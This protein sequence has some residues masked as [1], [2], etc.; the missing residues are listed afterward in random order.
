MKRLQAIGIMG[1]LF[2]WMHTAYAA[3]ETIF[4]NARIFTADQT[5]PAAQ[6][7]AVQQG[8]ILAIGDQKEVLA[9]QGPQTQII[10]L[11]DQRVLPGLIDAHTHAVIAALAE[12]S[13]NLADEELD[14]SVVAKRVQDGYDELGADPKTP[15]VVFGVNPGTWSDPSALLAAFDS[16][17]WTTTPLVLMGS[18]LHTAWANPAMLNRAG[19]DAAFAKSLSTAQQHIMG[20]DAVGQPTGVLIDA[21]VDLVTVHFS[22]PDDSLLL[23]AAQ[24]AVQHLNQYGITA[25][26]DPAANAGPGEALFSRAPGSTG[27]GILPAYALLSEKEGL[28]AHVAALLVASP[29]SD[30]AD[31]DHLDGIRQQFSNTPNLTLPGIKIFAD[32]VLEYPA[33]SAALLEVYKN[34][35]KQGELLLTS[36]G[37]QHLVDAADERGWLV[38]IHALGD[39]AVRESLDAFGVARKNRDSGIMH[40]VTHLQLVSEDDYARFADLNLLVVMQLLWAEADNYLLDLV[41]PYISAEQFNRQYPAHSLQKQGA[42][43]AGA[44]DWPISSANPWLAMHHAMTRYGPNGGLNPAERLDLNSMLLAYTRHAAQAIGLADE[45]GSLT[46]GKQADFIVL[47]RDVLEVDVESLAQTQ[48]LET[49]FAGQLVYQAQLPPSLNP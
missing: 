20:V 30:A 5:L 47:D 29:Q 38:H 36:A 32:G 19:I 27:T 39:R 43:I 14:L 26:M 24:Y 1:F 46:V 49:Y 42:L 12:L 28:T 21:G 44:S 10:D 48:V 7:L 37:L 16:D 15:F 8:R 6:A 13:P 34:S 25:W 45:I 31:L 41:Q 17:F 11:Q 22:A 35:G 18:D 23:R 40:S 9:H 4:I 2:F 3:P 33:Q